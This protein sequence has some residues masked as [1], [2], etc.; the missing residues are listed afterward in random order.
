MPDT[1]VSS[2]KRILAGAAH[3]AWMG[4]LV[5]VVIGMIGWAAA[6]ALFAFYPDWMTTVAQAPKE[7]IWTLTLRWMAGWKLLMYGWLVFA[8]FLSFWWRAL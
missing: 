4:L 8:G 1:A 3:G 5:G 2:A 7:E 6:V